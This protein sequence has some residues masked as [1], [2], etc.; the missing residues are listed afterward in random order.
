MITGL[1]FHIKKIEIL[2]HEK[3]RDNLKDV[4]PREINHTDW[5]ILQGSPYM[6]CQ[7]QAHGSK[8]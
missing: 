2:P 5:Q 4:M 3:K 1:L 7:K 6:S 8:E